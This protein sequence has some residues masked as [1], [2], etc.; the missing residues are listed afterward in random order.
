MNLK[1]SHER[2]IGGLE[3]KKGKGELIILVLSHLGAQ[4]INSVTFNN[5]LTIVWHNIYQYLT[6]KRFFYQPAS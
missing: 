5:K 6:V 2:C 1:D 4:F 3:G